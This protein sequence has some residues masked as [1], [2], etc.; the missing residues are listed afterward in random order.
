MVRTLEAVENVM[1]V[2]LG[3]APLLSDDII[4]L[5]LEICL[6]EIPL[7][8][9]LPL[10]QVL[11]LGPR[12]IQHGA[13]ALSL[14]PSRGAL[15]DKDGRLI[16]GRLYGSALFPRSLEMVRSAAMIGIPIIGAGGVWTDAD[17]ESMLKAGAMAV[18]TDACLW[19]P[20]EA[21]K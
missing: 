3:F 20:K 9:A 12:L 21:S 10:E 2:Q 6:G 1:A 19:V 4:L 13:H 15:Y 17:A 16:S 8:Y 11:T 7:I 14:A 18:E 5:N